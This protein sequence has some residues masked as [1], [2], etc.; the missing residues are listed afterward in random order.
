MHTGDYCGDG[1]GHERQ[2]ASF[3]ARMAG[4]AGLAWSPKGDEIWFG[5][6]KAGGEPALRAV[7]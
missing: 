6:A 7:T 4:A 3:V 1:A 2:E 5:G